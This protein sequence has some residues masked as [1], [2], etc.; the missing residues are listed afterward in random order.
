MSPG[1]FDEQTLKLEFSEAGD[2]KVLGGVRAFL[3]STSSFTDLMDDF[4]LVLGE[5]FVNARMYMGGRRAGVRTAPALASLFQVPQSDKAQLEK[6][7][8]D[9]D[10]SIGWGRYEFH[11]DYAS[12]K[13]FVLV[14]HS[15]LAEGT[16]SK[17]TANGKMTAMSARDSF[18]RCAL[19][20]G[21]LAGLSSYLLERQ[22]DMQE[23]ECIVQ[24]HPVCKFVV[25]DHRIH[26][27]NSGETE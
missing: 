8:S 6:I 23:T 9:L 2:L 27:Q 22:V 15:F 17:F 16:L 19:L 5:R 14:H 26:V 11:L 18:P 25:L 3:M 24:G 13:G 12:G 7:Y 10:C 21:Y 20:A 1:M 4:Y